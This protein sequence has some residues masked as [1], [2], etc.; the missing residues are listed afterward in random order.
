MV[1]EIIISPE[2]LF[3]LGVLMNAEFIDFDYIASLHEIQ[4]NFNAVKDKC[5]LNLSRRRL[6]S[7]KLNSEMSIDPKLK[8]MLE[9][10]FFGRL[11][12]SL[13]VIASEESQK[14]YAKKFHYLDGDCTMVN[15]DN[16]VFSLSH[17][18]EQILQ[19]IIH[20]AVGKH[21][22]KQLPKDGLNENLIT[23]IIIAKRAVVDVESTSLLI[24]EQ[25]DVLC[26]EDS[27]GNTAVINDEQAAEK[28][29]YMLKGE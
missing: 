26:T 10:V 22:A 28:I 11:E 7:K 2:E 3:F 15:I 25:D 8:K 17:V 5:I 20:D 12:T 21:T 29:K 14:K 16:G 18:T 9:C 13:D 27:D 23:R 6:V 1:N 24:V 19:E 4:R